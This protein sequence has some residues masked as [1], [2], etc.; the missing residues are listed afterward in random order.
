MKSHV[1]PISFGLGDLRSYRKPMRCV[2]ATS[3]L[4]IS[5]RGQRAAGKI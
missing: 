4:K 5:M 2:K 1:N 3:P